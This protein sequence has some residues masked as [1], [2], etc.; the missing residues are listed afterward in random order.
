MSLNWI[1][2]Q[3][4][5]LTAGVYLMTGVW[6]STPRVDPE[7]P[8]GLIHTPENQ[9]NSSMWYMS[10]AVPIQVTP[11]WSIKA[12][13]VGSLAWYHIDQYRKNNHR[14]TGN[15]VNTFTLR[16]GTSLNLSAYGYTRNRN[17]Y[18]QYDGAYYINAGV[19][20]QLFKDKMTVSLQ[21]NDIFGTHNSW[22]RVYNPS[23]Y[24]ESFFW[25]NR[26][27]LVVSM[28][29]KFKSGKEFRTR[30]VESN[31]DTSRISGRGN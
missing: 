10:A 6:V 27:M 3:K 12:N 30:R 17:E 14:I 29:Y 7:N 26:P 18:T 22:R 8:I 28:Q 25:G 9:S 19:V 4:Y 5:T 24:E 11:W 20:Q 23:F 31:V 13:L 16:E 15:L 21:V 1:I 2:R